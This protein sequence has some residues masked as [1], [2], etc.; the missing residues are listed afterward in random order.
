MLNELRR[1]L[2][3]AADAVETAKAD[4]GQ[5][6]SAVTSLLTD[7]ITL[8]A[9]L[10]AAAEAV[11]AFSGELEDRLGRMED[12]VDSLETEFNA[13]DGPDEPDEPD[14]F[15]THDPPDESPPGEA[16]DSDLAE[17]MDTIS[18]DEDT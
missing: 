11:D 4:L 5:I 13:L 15:I 16:L 8:E 9:A 2:E 10:R 14:D 7:F 3:D 6:G 17:L 18:N 12:R 1:N